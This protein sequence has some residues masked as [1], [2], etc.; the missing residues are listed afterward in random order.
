MTGLVLKDL[1]VLRKSLRTY[2]LFLIFYFIMALLDLFSS[3]GAH[4]K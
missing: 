1:L 3:L 4:I 2:L